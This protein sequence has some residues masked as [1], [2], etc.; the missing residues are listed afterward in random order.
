MEIQGNLCVKKQ[1]R[2]S[3]NVSDDNCWKVNVDAFQILYGC[4]GS[5]IAHH[6]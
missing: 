3:M 6:D 5:S 4:I 2:F 1:L